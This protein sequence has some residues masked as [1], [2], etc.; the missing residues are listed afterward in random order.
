MVITELTW[1]MLFYLGP[2]TLKRLVL[3]LIQ[4]EELNKQGAVKLENFYN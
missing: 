3:T 2:R 4:K 1:P